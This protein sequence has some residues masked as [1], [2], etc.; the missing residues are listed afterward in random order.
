MTLDATLVT[1]GPAQLQ[2][3]AAQVG[4]TQ[5][6][7]AATITPQVRARNVDRYGVGEMEQIHT[8]DEVRVTAPLCEWASA[9]LAEVYNAGNDQ[10]SAGSGSNPYLGVGRSSGYRYTT[11]NLRVIPF[12]S[13]DVGKRM[14][15]WKATP[16][17]ALTVNHDS[18][19]DRIFE[20]EF[21]CLVDE[22]KTD[23]E[24]NG[25]IYLSD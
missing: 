18:D 21:A 8:G 14:E 17:G 20:T 1:A 22:S 11:K 23:G 6:G 24:L 2:L 16:I 19:N 15:F 4:H 3:D 9:T 10:L 5:G 12:L 25:R 13:T 7:I